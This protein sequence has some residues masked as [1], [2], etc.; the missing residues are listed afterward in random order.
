[1]GTTQ[2]IKS[3]AFGEPNWGNLSSSLTHLAKT[4]EQENNLS[5]EKTEDEKELKRIKKELNKLAKKQK[6]YKENIY[7]YL[8]KISG[9]SKNGSNKKPHSFGKAGLKSSVKFARFIYSVGHSGLNVALKEFGVKNIEGKNLNEI[10]NQLFVYFSEDSIGLDE[11]A[12]NK[13]VTEVLEELAKEANNSLDEFEKKLNTIVNSNELSEII[14][15][16]F[17]HYIFE[18]LSQRFKEKIT[19]EKGG[20]VSKETFCLIK[21]DIFGQ[22]LVLN[23]KK[24]VKNIDWKGQ[25]GAIEIE[26]IFNSI[27][28]ILCE[29][30]EN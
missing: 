11:I 22:I 15:K 5:S 18:Y 19:S 14:C 30:D 10:I 20:P 25:E 3:G 8:K 2:R 29:E 27:I 16:F 1:M 12:A 4:I 28:N 23:A 9:G 13:A 26:K 17:G 24:S 7:N 6:K 21:E